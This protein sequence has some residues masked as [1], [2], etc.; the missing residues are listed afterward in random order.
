M[1]YDFDGVEAWQRPTVSAPM[2]DQR[3][4]EGI[5]TL[6]QLAAIFLTPMPE[7]TFTAKQLIEQA[8][9]L[10]G[11]EFSILEKDAEIVLKHSSF[12]KKLPRGLFRLK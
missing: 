3:D 7:S 6:L 12:L 2:L 11:D 10:G 4:L 1:A 8:K 9:E 5:V